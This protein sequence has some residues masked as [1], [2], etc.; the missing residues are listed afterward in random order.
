MTLAVYPTLPGLTFPVL[1]SVDFDTLV[2]IAPNKYRV[3]L[4]QTVNPQWSW[5]LIYDFLRDPATAASVVEDEV[6]FSLGDLRTLLGFFNFQR[7]QAGDFLFLDPDDHYVGP[8]MVGELPNIPLA[9]LQVVTDG[10]NYYS[11]LQRTFDGASYEDVTDLNTS[12]TGSALAVYA[13][14]ALTTAYTLA[15]PGLGLPGSSFM[16]I[17]LNWGTTA[18]D[19]PVTAQFSFYFRVHFE[20]DSQDMEKFAQA[21]W[22]V[23]GSESQNGKGYVRLVQSR[24][25]PL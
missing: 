2:S 18:P 3:A 23:G 1:K 15:G 11:P 22:T 14:G 13:N 8:A 19:A 5:E 17:Y 21:F 4:S 12:S 9:E 25:Q 24:P 16:G 20:S 6:V 7:G 10:T